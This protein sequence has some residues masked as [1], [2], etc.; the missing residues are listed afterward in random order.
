M[1][2]HGAQETPRAFYSPMLGTLH[3]PTSRTSSTQGDQQAPR[4]TYRYE[5]DSKTTTKVAMEGH[6]RFENVFVILAMGNGPFSA[7]GMRVCIPTKES[8]SAC[9]DFFGCP[10][11]EFVHAVLLVYDLRQNP[12]PEGT[13]EWKP[14]Y[15]VP[16]NLPGGLHVQLVAME[17][18]NMQGDQAAVVPE[19]LYAIVSGGFS[20][21]LCRAAM[22]R[23]ASMLAVPLAHRQRLIE[24]D[25]F[26]WE[27]EATSS[28]VEFATGLTENQWDLSHLNEH[29]FQLGTQTIISFD[30]CTFPE[31]VTIHQRPNA[32]TSHHEGEPYKD[33]YVLTGCVQPPGLASVPWRNAIEIDLTHIAMPTTTDI[34][35]AQL[36]IQ[37]PGAWQW[38]Q[39][40]GRT[41]QQ[42][43][44]LFAVTADWVT[45]GG[46]VVFNLDKLSS[47]LVSYQLG[48]RQL[49]KVNAT[50]ALEFVA[51][52]FHT[53]AL[54]GANRV[55]LYPYNGVG[56][57]AVVPLE[58]KA[59]KGGGFAVF[60][61][62]DPEDFFL[63]G[64][65]DGVEKPYCLEVFQEDG[66]LI[67]VVFSKTSS[68]FYRI[69]NPG[70]WLSSDQQ[71]IS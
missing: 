42:P 6:A 51:K 15:M 28:W 70:G 32:K 66:D 23:G 54:P 29:A 3:P 5:E 47:W 13:A 16:L 48:G 26:P 38:L 8:R 1:A 67:V 57:L 44:G 62:T 2:T 7:A 37:A 46:L 56:M 19:T 36:S 43:S 64:R 55:V 49:M 24:R 17:S 45:A 33:T 39:L 60:D 27:Q 59:D 11:N 52:Q 14:S 65:S 25:S 22:G 63:V 9:M 71:A 35:C 41:Y 4:P 68:F 61:V 30:G 53:A 21:S 50:G 58:A 40:V 18:G 31:S 20:Q 10:Q 69:R 12:P 34:C